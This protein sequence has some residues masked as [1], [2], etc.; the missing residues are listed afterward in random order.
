VGSVVVVEVDPPLV[1]A[2][3]AEDKNDDLEPAL[4]PQ[5]ITQEVATRIAK[6]LQIVLRP[7][8]KIDL[9]VG[10]TDAELRLWDQ[11]SPVDRLN[12]LL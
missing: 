6:H 3:V 4:V 11:V 5:P 1:V 10:D 9:R 12:P 2:A 8:R 7:S